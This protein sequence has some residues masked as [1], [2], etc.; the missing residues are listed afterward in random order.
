MRLPKST[1]LCGNTSLHVYRS[2]KSV[3]RY[4]TRREPKYKVPEA[5]LSQRDRAALCQLQS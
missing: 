2:L 3:N 4:E 1:S 5:L